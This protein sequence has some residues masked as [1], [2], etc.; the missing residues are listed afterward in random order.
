MDPQIL[1]AIAGVGMSFAGFVGL[2][3]ALRQ[4]S[5]SWSPIEV[6]MIIGIVTAGLGV[7]L[8]ALAPIPL[9]GLFGAPGVLRIASAAFLGFALFTGVRQARRGRRLA[10]DQRGRA[11]AFGFVGALTLVVLGPAIYTGRVEL[12]ELG[13]LVGLLV[14]VLNFTFVVS[15]LA[16]TRD[17]P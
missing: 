12:Y 17:R 10:P 5:G 16:H 9:A 14:P 8:F 1:P 6:H 3:A 15:D 4:R 7:V 11:L 13:L 2:F